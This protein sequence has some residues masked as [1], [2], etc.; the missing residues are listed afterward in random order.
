MGPAS[1]LSCR[2]RFLAFVREDFSFWKCEEDKIHEQ[3]DGTKYEDP[4]PVDKQT[5]LDHID[6]A[7]GHLK[8]NLAWEMLPQHHLQSHK[9]WF[10][11]HL[12]CDQHDRL[13]AAS[14][15]AA[16]LAIDDDRQMNLLINGADSCRTGRYQVIFERLELL[17]EGGGAV[18]SHGESTSFPP[19]HTKLLQNSADDNIQAMHLQQLFGGLKQSSDHTKVAS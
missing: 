18:W 8:K 4:N 12:F 1:T 17:E 9:L 3:L 5:Q 2:M 6:K 10:G 13:A 16:C 14:C 19:Y 15:A 11:M 7:H